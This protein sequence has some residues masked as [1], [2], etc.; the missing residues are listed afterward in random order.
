MAFLAPIAPILGILGA[1]T[2][3]VGTIMGGEATAANATYQAEV[4]ANNAKV[5]YANA[6]RASAAGQEQAAQESE[7]GAQ[8]EAQIVGAMA[9]NNIDVRSGSAINVEKGERKINQL[10]SETVLSNAELQNYG[11]RVQ[12]T[13]D[14]AQAQLYQTEAQEA[15]LA[16][17]IGAVGGLLGG[18]SSI[19]FKFGNV[20]WSGQG[21]VDSTAYSP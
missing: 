4:A 16:A 10:N 14:L 17:D 18:A 12:A 3:A 8:R 6:E 1:A 7:K 2:S 13:N 19:G 9:A 21:T 11:Y 15:P 5:A 20:D